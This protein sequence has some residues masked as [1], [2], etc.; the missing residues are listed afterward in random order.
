M[1][2]EYGA[3]RFKTYAGGVPQTTKISL[4]FAELNIITKKHIEAGY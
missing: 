1:D 3:E 4:N 2:V